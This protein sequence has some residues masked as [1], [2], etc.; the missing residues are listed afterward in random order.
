MRKKEEIHI[1]NKIDEGEKIPVN[2]ISGSESG[3][4]SGS[5]FINIVV[6][7]MVVAVAVVVV[8]EIVVVLIG[9]ELV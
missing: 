8:V 6:V 7:V 1:L 3:I 9:I 2:V 5:L 4:I